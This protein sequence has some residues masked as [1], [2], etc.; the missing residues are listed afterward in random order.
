MFVSSA[1]DSPDASYINY[2]LWQKTNKDYNQKNRAEFEFPGYRKKSVKEANSITRRHYL[3]T[4]H[5][6]VYKKTQ[7]SAS[8]KGILDL[9]W[10]RVEFS[11]LKEETQG[12]IYEIKIIKNLKF[13]CVYVLNL[14]DLDQIRKQLARI[15]L[16]TDFDE[17][18]KLEG[19]ISK[20]NFGTVRSQFQSHSLPISNY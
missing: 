19:F 18:Y 17:K 6:L 13:T 1:F 8:V 4:G 16:L 7:N 11:T 2:Q 3:I 15:C 12:E 20:G 10:A 9:R 14:E 5:F